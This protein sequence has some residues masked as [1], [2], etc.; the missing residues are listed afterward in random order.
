MSEI[1]LNELRQA[2]RQFLDGK[3]SIEAEATKYC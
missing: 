2:S 3:T 1:S